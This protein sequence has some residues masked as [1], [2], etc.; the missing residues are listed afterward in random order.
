M[1]RA[2]GRE[3]NNVSVDAI[4][5]RE[6]GDYSGDYGSNGA[7]TVVNYSEAKEVLRRQSLMDK[8]PK[9]PVKAYGR[10]P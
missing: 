10:I 8:V 1:K 4:Q 7:I 2:L 6:R 3:A 9:I 5:R